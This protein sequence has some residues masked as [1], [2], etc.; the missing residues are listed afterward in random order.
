MRSDARRARR[1]T[2]EP[3]D[4][5]CPVALPHLELDGP[6]PRFLGDPLGPE[7][8]SPADLPLW[9]ACDGSMS[10]AFWPVPQREVLRRWHAEGLL[11][12]APPPSRQQAVDVLVV[13][14]HP[15]DAQLALGALLA[16]ASGRVI[17]V[18]SEETWTRRPYYHARPELTGRLL[19]AE[20]R[21]A[22]RVL[23]AQVTLL[24]H[25]D[26][27][28]RVDAIFAADPSGTVPVQ[29]EPELFDSLVMT[30]SM[31]LGGGAPVLAPLGVGGH[32]DH[33]LAREAALALIARQLLD[34]AR[35]AFYEDMPYAVR[36]DPGALAGRLARRAGLGPL[37]PALVPAPPERADRKRESL[38]TYRLQLTEGMSDR[39][40]QYGRRVAAA[41]F[42]ERLWVPP[43]SIAMDSL[44]LPG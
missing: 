29:A 5:A 35:I 4:S 9:R 26:G 34:P 37:R 12:M 8:L 32:V 36:A 24:G 31:A 33:V 22:C 3:G 19:L 39:V 7:I 41:G 27:A 13:A 38:W 18:F 2:G 30:L 14:P 28:N 10:L 43:G 20:E 16:G 42:A 11:V 44:E 1:W 17:N 15:D 25:V 40:L 21:V 6:V 23:G